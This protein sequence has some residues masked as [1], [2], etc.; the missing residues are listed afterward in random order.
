MSYCYDYPRAAVTVDALIFRNVNRGIEVLLIRRGREPF[1]NMWA[2]PGGFIE[3][4]ETLEEAILRE[5][6]EETGLT[7]IE[8]KQFHTFSSVKRDPRHRTISTVF[9]GLLT[10]NS[11]KVVAGDDAEESGWFS[12][13]DLPLLA[14]DHDEVISLAIKL[15]KIE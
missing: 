12:I 10:N 4:D 6:Q 13:T 11:I 3:M 14:F 2:L 1:K 15:I 9:W 7:G 8:L 5:L